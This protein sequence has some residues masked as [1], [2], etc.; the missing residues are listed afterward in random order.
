MADKNKEEL[1]RRAWRVFMDLAEARK[2][3]AEDEAQQ[4][5][6]SQVTAYALFALSELPPGPISQLAARL[7]V[8]PGWATDIV[9]KLE[10]YGAVARKQSDD[11]RR[12]RVV[13][14]TPAGR[15]I[16]AEVREIALRAPPELLG[17][18]ER[19]L[20]ALTRIAEELESIADAQRVPPKTQRRSM[21]GRLDDLHERHLIKRVRR[22][23]GR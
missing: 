1:A 19:E 14:L 15:R 17:L 12:V 2:R 9:D 20:G 11:D 4:L 23:R 8:D 5:G 7:S 22:P 3:I 6:L 18:G 21:L 10:E 16:A 13:E